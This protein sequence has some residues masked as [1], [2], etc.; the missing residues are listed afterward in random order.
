MRGASWTITTRPVFSTLCGDAARC[1]AAT[2][3]ADRSARSRCP[4]AAACSTACSASCT[5]APQAITVTPVAFAQHLAP[6]PAA[7]RS[8]PR[9]PRPSTR[10]RCAWARRRAPDPCCRIAASSRPFASYGL[11]RRHH[12][13]PGRVDEERLGALRV[14]VAALDAAAERSADHHRARVLPARAVAQLGQLVDD[15]IER[16][17]DEVAR[18]GSR[19]PAC[20]PYIAMPIA[21]PMMP[22]SASGVSI[23]RSGPNSSYRPAVARKT[24]PNLPTSSPST[25][26]ARDRAASRRAARRS[27]PAA[28]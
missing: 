8:R 4:S 2:A 12:L 27:R 24:P 28:G 17:E 14:V 15:L 1:P 5:I 11:R 18:T 13:Q 26:D 9:A 21:A 10:G 25:T 20:R 22:P 3:C 23:T 19:A 7:P 16:R 6:C